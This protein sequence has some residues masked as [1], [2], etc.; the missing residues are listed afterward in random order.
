MNRDGKLTSRRL[1]ERAYTFLSENAVDVAVVV[2]AEGRVKYVSPWIK[3]LFGYDPEALIGV[4]GLSVVH[5]DDHPVALTALQQGVRK[6]GPQPLLELRV[7]RADGSFAHVEVASRNCLDDPEINGFVVLFRDISRYREAQTGAEQQEAERKRLLTALEMTADSVVV[8]DI[9]GTIVYANKATAAMWGAGNASELIGRNS[10]DLI[11]PEDIESALA[12]MQETLKRGIL[13]N[14]T[15]RVVTKHGSRVPVEMTAALIRDDS[16]NPSGFVG[17]SRDVTERETAAASRR[18]SELKYWHLFETIPDAL[19][20]ADAATRR[21]VEANPAAESLFGY[22]REELVGMNMTGIS[23]EPEATTEA[24]GAI[25]EGRLSRVPH[26]IFQR[27][28][29]SRFEA[30]IAVGMFESAGQKY[31]LGHFRDISSRLRA[32]ESLRLSEARFRRMAE[33]APDIVMEGNPLSGIEYIN[34]RVFDVLGYKPE[35]IIGQIGFLA[36]KIHPDDIPIFI[37]SLQTLGS[38]SEKENAVSQ[39][40]VMRKDG[41]YVVVELRFTALWDEQRERLLILQAVARDITERKRA[42]SALQESSIQYR[43]VVGQSRDPIYIY[44]PST[45]RVIDAN[46]AFLHLLGYTGED[47]GD[48]TLPHFVDH[49]VESIRGFLEVVLKRGSLTIGERTWKRKD[50]SRVPVHVYISRIRRESGDLIFVMAHD[51]T[52][53]KRMEAERIKWSKLES[54][55]VLAGGI[56]H[57]FNNVLTAVLGNVTYAKRDSVAGSEQE[58]VLLEAE[59]ACLRAKHLTR[60]LLTFARGGAPMKQP[61]DIA[62]LVEE[63]ARM[64]GSGSRVKLRTWL[65]PGLNPADADP[66]QIGQAVQNLVLNAVQATP[67]GGVVEVR[68]E[69]ILGRSPLEPESGERPFVKISVQDWGEGIPPEHRDRIYDPYF[70][71]KPGGTGLGLATVHS[72]AQRHGG[73]LEVRSEVGAGTTVEMFIPTSTGMPEPVESSSRELNRGTGRILLMDDERDVRTTLSRI[74]KRLGYRVR[75]S[76]EGAQALEIYRGALVRGRKFD[77]VITDLTV[78][79]GMGGAELIVQLLR[80]DPSARAIVSSGY[81]GDPV[82]ARFGEYG[83][84]A[85]LAK[86]YRMEEVG[87]TLKEVLS[88]GD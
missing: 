25:L 40:R 59:R 42:E 75:L 56:A 7:R 43:A 87:R 57:D 39:L 54:I 83:F 10:F 76:R 6:V 35:E 86:P 18:E 47:C 37:E 80:M 41:G 48:L 36:S 85:F 72:I 44:E 19:M 38:K 12:G 62:R 79:G 67:N 53:Q 8:S 2:D 34:G 50:G 30:E 45:L 82:L 64:A 33:T 66:G 58:D 4:S 9:T 32:E 26:R 46:A 31:V 65:E 5:P 29:G 49:S 74:L 23:A 88:A 28:D 20:I 15:Y 22:S 11:A 16:G 81:S 70:T 21:I 27:K 78:P 3:R 1:A 55:G 14:R 24:I 71:T 61:T 73:H 17:I 77:A 52:E 63:S 84:K 13:L 60:Q 68:A 69:N 51:L